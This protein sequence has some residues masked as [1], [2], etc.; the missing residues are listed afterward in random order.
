VLDVARE[1]LAGAVEEH[2]VDPEMAEPIADAVVAA[3]AE[4][5]Y[6]RTDSHGDNNE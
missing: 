1:V 2:D 3:L 4:A 5:G 6:L